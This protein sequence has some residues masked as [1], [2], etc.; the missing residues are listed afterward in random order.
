MDIDI[1]ISEL[2]FDQEIVNVPGLGSFTAKKLPAQVDEAKNQLSPPSK[3]ITFEPKVKGFDEVL[4]NYIC[5]KA[6]ISAT[7]ASQKVKDFVKTCKEAVIDGKVVVLSKLGKLS[8]NDKGDYIFEQDPKT[9]FNKEAFG[10]QSFNASTFKQQDTKKIIKEESKKQPKKKAKKIDT[11]E[12]KKSK[13]PIIILGS[14][15]AILIAVGVLA[16]LNQDLTKK[17]IGKVQIMISGEA[18]IK[19]PGD[20][21]GALDYTYMNKVLND[22]SAHDAIYLRSFIDSTLV[23]KDFAYEAGPFYAVIPF[24]SSKVPNILREEEPQG[25]DIVDN[26][27]GDTD[28]NISSKNFHVIAGSFEIYGNATRYSENL[29]TQGYPNS[30]VFKKPYNGLH[31]VT[32]N[33]YATKEE[34]LKELRRFRSEINPDSWVLIQ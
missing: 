11:G 22:T 34:A 30:R 18:E 28:A 23:T 31:R 8:M 25:G 9:N 32:Y 12:K 6:K 21:R 4:V 17:Y 5:E 14:V 20:Q 2:L 13:T 7:E 26:S 16:Y 29:K 10:M 19:L 27:Q 24:M 15:A 1:Y 3:R 33:S